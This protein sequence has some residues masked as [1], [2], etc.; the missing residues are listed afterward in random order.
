M[1]ALIAYIESRYSHCPHPRPIHYQMHSKFYVSVCHYHC[2]Y[3]GMED[4]VGILQ[5]NKGGPERVVFLTEEI[6]HAKASR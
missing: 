2:C 4:Q 1:Q 6:P 3:V 5:K